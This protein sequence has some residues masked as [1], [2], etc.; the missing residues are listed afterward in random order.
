MENFQPRNYRIDNVELNYPKLTKAVSPFGVM[1]YELQI[2]TMDPAE[3]EAW[4]A[5][6]LPVKPEIDKETKKPTGKFTV[7]LKRKAQR[8]DGS[9]NGAPEVVDADALPMDA[10]KLGNGSRG[11]V[12]IYQ[13][14]YK[15]AGRE[16]ISNSLTSV[17]VAEYKEYTGSASF[18]PITKLAPESSFSPVAAPA[19]VAEEAAPNPF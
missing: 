4:K 7:S 3:A 16:G 19:A 9:D 14:Y 15:N 8:Q 11:N 10:S 13:M 12:I 17:Q 1:Q 2:A 18:E 6:H 5:N